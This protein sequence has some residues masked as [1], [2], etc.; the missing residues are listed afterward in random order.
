MFI[1]KGFTL[2]EILVAMSL[3]ITF[4][5]LIARS[6]NSGVELNVET[7][8]R[9]I[10][11]NK[12]RD[13]IRNIS[14]AMRGTVPLG[15]CEI[16]LGEII[17]QKCIKILYENYPIISASTDSV[18]FFSRNR[19]SSVENSHPNLF[20]VRLCLDSINGCSKNLF[21]LSEYRHNQSVDEYV[22]AKIE[23]KSPCLSTNCPH[24]SSASDNLRIGEIDV[25]KQILHNCG[26]REIFRYYDEYGRKLEPQSNCFLSSEDLSKI[27]LVI[28]EAIFSYGSPFDINQNNNLPILKT[29]SMRTTISLPSKIYGV[30]K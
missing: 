29:F 21:L 17:T 28:M 22:N 24:F 20:R 16:P 19:S 23:W 15:R 3:S 4:S 14:T 8:K 7:S 9:I 11:E 1:K 6:I 12:A 25:S 5:V 2:V 27:K 26:Q 18:A 13:A 30:E 10:A